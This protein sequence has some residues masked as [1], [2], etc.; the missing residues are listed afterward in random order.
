M[1]RK[2]LPAR[3]SAGI[4]CILCSLYFVHGAVVADGPEGA[5][6]RSRRAM[7]SV[8]PV[9]GGAGIPHFDRRRVRDRSTHKRNRTFAELRKPLVNPIFFQT[10]T[11]PSG[12]Y[13]PDSVVIADVNG[14]GKGDLVVAS[15]CGSGGCNNSPQGVVGV[16]LGNG[17]GTFQAA[18]TYSSGGSSATSVAVADVNA[19]GR[20]DVV[21]TNDCQANC[22]SGTT[23]GVV[24]VLLSNGDGSFQPAQSY[25]AAGFGTIAMALADMNHDGKPDIVVANGCQTS[26]CFDSGGN[27]SVLLG[28]GNGTF[29]PAQSYSAGGLSPVSMVVAD[30]NGDGTPDA[31][32]GYENAVNGTSY[33]GVLLGNQDGSLQASR[34]YFGGYDIRSMA[35]A[36]MNHDGK[37]DVVIG[38]DCDYDGEDCTGAGTIIIQLGNGDGTFRYSRYMVYG[39]GV[40]FVAFVDTDGDG[41]LDLVAGRGTFGIFRGNGDGSFQLPVSYES[42]G[43][44]VATG[45]VN[46][47]SRPDLVFADGQNSVNILLQNTGGTFVAI[48]AYPVAYAGESAEAVVAADVNG[49]HKLDLISAIFD[50]GPSTPDGMVSVSLGNGDGSFQTD[51]TYSSGGWFTTTVAVADVNSD[52]KPD[53]IVASETCPGL[54]CGGNIGV[55]LGNGDGTFQKA[56]VYLA[57]GSDSYPFSIAVADVNGDGKPDIVL[58]DACL[59]FDCTTHGIGVLLG[60]GDGTFQPEQS[61]ASGGE[62]A[63]SVAIA[64]VNV[65]GKPDI[66]VADGCGEYMCSDGRAAVLLGNGDGTF[67]APQTYP[68][69]GDSTESISIADVNQD[70]ILDILVANLCSSGNCNGGGTNSLGVFLGNGDGTFQPVQTYPSGGGDE[71]AVADV[72]LDGIPDVVADTGYAGVSVLLGNGDGTFQAP[73]I[74]QAAGAFALADLNG[75]GRLDLAVAQGA[76]VSVLTNITTGF[77]QT[78][79]TTLTSAPNPSVLNQLVTLTAR[80]L[81]ATTS[82]PPGVGPS[83]AVIFYDGGKGLGT[84]QVSSGVAVLTVSS[85][86]V[87]SHLIT[88]AYAGDSSHLGSTSSPLRQ[89]VVVYASGQ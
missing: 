34:D 12:G 69:G 48:P 7:N 32:V 49:D 52:G 76:L 50:T 39:N 64:D 23:P 15:Y 26:D 29:Q 53:I 5:Y 43:T 22:G 42:W 47:D 86:G 80:V 11:Y 40:N 72:N 8:Q 83:G 24:S 20:P 44:S 27:V 79:R 25:T 62:S 19:D 60:N 66:L 28:N 41:N 73:S 84:K 63:F 17:D 37:P 85:L 13:A 55:L 59:S 45:D 38:G 1:T 3:L 75:N 68:S 77:R 67:G 33:F 36:D 82:S 71:L 10:P 88:A 54:K 14:D 81:I 57:G 70:G 46:G 56:V 6:P 87:G 58:A 65:D 21:V 31:I 2:H 9:D 16:L 30:V 4:I 18:Q 35:V 74:Y 78:T 89:T 51:R 61:Y